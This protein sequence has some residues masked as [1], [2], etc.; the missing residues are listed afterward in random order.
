[1]SSDKHS[2]KYIIFFLFLRQVLKQAWNLLHK[3]GCYWFPVL[4]LPLHGWYSFSYN[5]GSCTPVP[6]FLWLC[7]LN[8]VTFFLLLHL[9]KSQLVTFKSTYMFLFRVKAVIHIILI[10]ISDFIFKLSDFY[11]SSYC[12]LS[13][14]FYTVSRFSPFSFKHSFLHFL[15]KSLHKSAKFHCYF[16]SYTTILFGWRNCE[17]YTGKY[18]H[19][20]IFFN[21]RWAV[22]SQ[23]NCGWNNLIR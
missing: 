18:L 21:M 22:F 14:S 12:K 4:L 16:I 1:M 7:S 5:A 10:H 17:Y 20:A 2:I 8:L 6:M 15:T 9:E 23:L 19:F 3:W 11:L 13:C